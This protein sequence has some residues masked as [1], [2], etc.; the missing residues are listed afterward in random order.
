M[1][2]EIPLRLKYLEHANGHNKA[3]SGNSGPNRHRGLAGAAK[4]EA[5]ALTMKGAK[6]LMLVGGRH[7]VF[8]PREG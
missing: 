5:T 3:S 6:T 7:R 1:A 4:A 8:V 2:V